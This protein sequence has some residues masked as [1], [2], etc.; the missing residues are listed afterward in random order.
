MSIIIP[1]NS[2]VSGGFDVANSLMFDKPSN[3]YLTRTNGGNG[4]ETKGT[5]SVW[6]KRAVLDGASDYMWHTSEDTNNDIKILTNSDNNFRVRGINNGSV[7]VNL[8]SDREFEDVGAWYHLVVA[9]DSTQGTAANRVKMYING[10]QETSFSSSTYPSQNLNLKINQSGDRRT[11]G[12]AYD[13]GGTPVSGPNAGWSGYMAEAV[14]IDGTALSPTDFGEFDE[15]SLIW[16]PISVSG[17]TFGTNGFYL[18]FE[19][20]SALGN[21]AAGSNN[22]SV[23]GIAATDQGLDTCTNNFAVNNKLSNIASR[24]TM[25]NGNNTIQHANS[26]A[27][28]AMMSSIAPFVGKYYMEAKITGGASRAMFGVMSA[29][30]NIMGYQTNLNTICLYYNLSGGE[31]QQSGSTTSGNNY[32]TFADN[33]IAGI[34]LDCTNKYISIYKNGSALVTNHTIPATVDGSIG[35]GFTSDNNSTIYQCNYG[36]GYFGTT[37]VASANADGNGVGKMEY[38]VPTGYYTLN[39][40]NLKEFG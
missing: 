32:G 21:D 6:L 22:F 7:V 8:I 24:W 13:N 16:K 34:A 36:N 1:A 27:W 12:T 4:S 40:K 3:P 39:T 33:D 26:G 30:T 14:W 10:V 2:A 11:I 31:F 18:D 17:L 29:D 23:S 28:T 38:A 37:A 20:S 25:T 9:F 35:F 15:D 5:Y 19:D